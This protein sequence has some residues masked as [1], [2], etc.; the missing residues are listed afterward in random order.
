VP[1]AG[2]VTAVQIGPRRGE[3]LARLVRAQRLGHGVAHG[4]DAVNCV[5]LRDLRHG[6]A[7]HAGRD[8]LTLGMVGI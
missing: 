8:R 1:L 5:E 3:P 6:V 2:G 7:Q 4:V